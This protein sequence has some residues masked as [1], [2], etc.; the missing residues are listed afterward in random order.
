M[1]LLAATLIAALA[2]VAASDAQPVADHLECYKVKD[3]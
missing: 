3:S 1:R 2:H